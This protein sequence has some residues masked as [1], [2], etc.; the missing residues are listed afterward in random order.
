[1][2]KKCILSTSI[3]AAFHVITGGEGQEIYISQVSKIRIFLETTGILFT[4]FIT[5]Y[6]YTHIHTHFL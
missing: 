3:K 4:L 6:V 5:I 2:K 1:M